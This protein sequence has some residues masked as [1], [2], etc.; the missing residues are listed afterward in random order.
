MVLTDFDI[1]DKA[2]KNPVFSSKVSNP[3]S[4]LDF[5]LERSQSGLPEYVNEIGLTTGNTQT[6]I[7]SDFVHI[8]TIY[9]VFS[10]DCIVQ[11][12]FSNSINE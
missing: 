9:K 8:G 12:V 1:I 3:K 4:R 2:F 6:A 7:G 5:D 11:L 10:A